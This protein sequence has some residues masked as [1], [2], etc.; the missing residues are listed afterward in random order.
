MSSLTQ[1][2][3]RILILSMLIVIAACSSSSNEAV[4]N[5]D[6]SGDNSSS[7][8]G[9]NGGDSSGG[10]DNGDDSDTDD[11]TDSVNLEGYTLIWQDEFDGTELNTNDWNYEFGDGTEFNLPAGWGNDELQIYTSNAENVSLGIDGDANVLKI[12]ALEDG[13]GGYTSARVTTEDKISVRYG[14]IVARIKLPESQGIWPAFWMLGDNIDEVSW[15]GSGEVDVVE[16]VGSAPDETFHTLH[17]VNGEQS[18]N[19]NGNYYNQA[20]KFSENY[21]EFMVDW[22]PS[23]ITW[24]VDGNQAH[25]VTLTDDMKEFQRSFHLLL[26]VAVGGRLPGNPDETSTFPQ[27]MYVDYVRAYELDGFSPDP[28]PE[29]DIDEETV[30]GTSVGDASPIEAIL[31]GFDALAPV[32]FARFGAGGEPDWFSSTDSIDGNYSV[33]FAYPGGSWGGAWMELE[34]PT[35]LRAYSQS[36]LVFAIKKPDTITG[37]EVKIEGS[38]PSDGSMFLENYTPTDLGNDWEE[39]RI[40]M[41]DFVADGLSLDQIVI[42]FALWNPMAANGSFPEV[43]ILFDA[44]RFE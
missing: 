39:Y 37:L 40:P 32:S 43:D 19:F 27:T 7:G 28:E 29:L 35:D 10:N 5:D 20:A 36:D 13:N 12:T 15:P 22:T 16:L 17:Y 18:Y 3:S 25:T 23:S 8:G 4:Q 26:N 41:A 42:P 30:G 21:H 44:I 9:G 34:G 33:R 38:N 2:I 1:I 11:D 24:Y 31:T 14:K 6:L